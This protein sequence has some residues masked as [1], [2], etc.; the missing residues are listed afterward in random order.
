MH[1]L[2][3]SRVTSRFSCH[4]SLLYEILRIILHNIIFNRMPYELTKTFIALIGGAE[5][6]LLLTKGVMTMSHLNND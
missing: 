2:R 4:K 5:P 6:N 1:K 3:I